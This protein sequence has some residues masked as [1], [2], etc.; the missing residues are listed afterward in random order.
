M[1]ILKD[2]IFNYNFKKRQAIFIMSKN[3]NNSKDY[4]TKYR[5]DTTTQYLNPDLQ[6]RLKDKHLKIVLKKNVVGSG[7][8]VVVQYGRR[9]K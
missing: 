4:Y 5:P 2:I 9:T 8:V 1:I 3:I 6:N 7:K